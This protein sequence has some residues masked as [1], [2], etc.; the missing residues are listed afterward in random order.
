MLLPARA[1]ALGKATDA[2]AYAGRRMTLVL[3][4]VRA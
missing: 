1:R 3:T 4:G 2:V